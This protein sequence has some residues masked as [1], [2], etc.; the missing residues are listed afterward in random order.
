[1]LFRSA[2]DGTTYSQ[3]DAGTNTIY[4]QSDSKSPTLVDPIETV[5]AALANGTA[6]VA[7]TVTIDGRSLYRIELPNGVVG[8]F[9]QTDYRPV[10]LDN[11]Q[12][13]GSVVRTRVITYAELPIT[14]QNEKLLSIA[15]QH[16]GVRLATGLPPAPSK[17]PTQPK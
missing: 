10:Y 4:Q 7:G 3:Y 14:P 16:P 9:D 15:A 5:R 1:M 8:Y 6:Q 12:R 17:G 2:A 11:P 13:G